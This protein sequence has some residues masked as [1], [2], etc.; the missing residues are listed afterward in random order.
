M[1]KYR[2]AAKSELDAQREY[3]DSLMGINRNNDRQGD[4]VK[5]FRDERVCKFF[6]T[7][8]CPHD[9]FVNTKLDEGPCP[10]VHSDALKNDF[11]AAGDAGMYDHILEREFNYRLSEADRTIKR[12]RLRVE[13]DRVDM[14]LNPDLNP[15][16][17][18]IHNE[19]SRIIQDAERAG[20]VGDIDKAQDL[21]MNRFE[22]LQKEKNTIMVRIRCL[23]FIIIVIDV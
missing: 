4:A 7:G 22:D 14:E 1:V 12:A 17:I 13:D 20:D 23:H 10:K 3:L 15:D 21:I 18:R 5:D 11:E 6:I 19:M 9:L 8:M 2:D 16:M